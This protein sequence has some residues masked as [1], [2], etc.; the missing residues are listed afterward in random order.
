MKKVLVAIALT[1]VGVGCGTADGTTGGQVAA[2]DGSGEHT[3]TQI[4]SNVA[5]APP[6]ETR[7]IPATAPTSAAGKEDFIVWHFC[8]EATC[9]AAGGYC[10]DGYCE[11][12]CENSP[13]SCTA[14][15]VDMSGAA[16][17]VNL[18]CTGTGNGV[19]R[20]YFTA[21]PAT[22]TGLGEVYPGGPWA[23]WSDPEYTNSNGDFVINGSPMKFLLD[24]DNAYFPGCLN[25]EGFIQN[26]GDCQIIAT[27]VEV[28]AEP[29]T[30]PFTSQSGVCGSG[31]E[32]F[33]PTCVEV[34]V[35]Y[36]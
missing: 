14:N 31:G 17:F 27:F 26:Q 2:D 22:Q 29:G 33:Y 30:A 32:S 36:P 8:D 24:E 5:T 4:E 11:P 16:G 1:A 28:C 35:T 3:P 7:S 12:G 19:Y 18:S 6:T 10:S 20:V 25:R 9:S 21:A 23:L 13:M 34:P 15:V